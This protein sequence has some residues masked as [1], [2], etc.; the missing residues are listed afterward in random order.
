MKSD[1]RKIDAEGCLLDLMREL[2]IENLL[3]SQKRI[4]ANII[5]LYAEPLKD[6]NAEL[7]ACLEDIRVLAIDYDGCT[8]VD[9]LR[10][11]IDELR[12][13][14]ASRKP[15]YTEKEPT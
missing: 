3:V 10:G 6:E 7:R 8:T 13:L 12:V 9:G 15:L 5:R 11:L 14:A 2:F 1:P 4:L